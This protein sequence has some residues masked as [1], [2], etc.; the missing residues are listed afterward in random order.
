MVIE[1]LGKFVCQ[2]GEDRLG[3][4]GS[5]TGETV[6]DIVDTKEGANVGYFHGAVLGM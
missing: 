6:E 3:H 4:R 5:F 1:L 2:Y